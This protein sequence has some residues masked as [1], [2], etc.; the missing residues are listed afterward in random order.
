NEPTAA[1]IAYGYQVGF[2]DQT[3]RAQSAKPLRVLVYDLGGGTFDVT[4]VEIQGTSFKALATDGDVSLGGKDWDDKL[5]EMAADAFIKV[6]REDPRTHPASLLDLFLAAE[7]AKKTLSERPK[8]TL[9]VNHLGTRLKLEIT[10]QEFE[11]AT[12]TLLGRTRTTTEIV[13]R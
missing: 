12:A 9:Y 5:V 2:L 4:I 10:R 3:G 6:H 8:A 13:V 1:A 11:D 7:L